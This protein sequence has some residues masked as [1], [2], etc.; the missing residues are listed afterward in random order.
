M[1]LH[2]LLPHVKPAALAPPTT[3]PTPD[4]LGATFR[5]HPQVRKAVR[6][7]RYT[8]VPAARY[9]C[10]LCHH[11]FRV[12]PL[13]VTAAHTSQRVRG[14]GVMFYLL[15]LSYGASALALEALGV[16]LA[17]S[18]VYEAV[19]AAVRGLP[20]LQQ[21]AVFAGLRTPALGADLTSVLCNGE[22]RTLGLTV[23]AV[24]GLT[25]RIDLLEGS[26]AATIQEWLAPIVE[27][28]GAE[29][30][31]T[32]DA[33]S[34]KQAADGLG[35]THQVCKAPVRRNTDALV[36][37][38]VAKVVGDPDGSLGAIGVPVEQAQADLR[39]L[40]EVVRERQPEQ[41]YE[42]DALHQ[43][44]KDAAPPAKG[45]KWSLAYRLRQLFLDRAQLWQRLTRY[46]S[47]EGPEGEQI[48]GTN[49]ASERG[50]GWWVKER[51]RT[52]RGYKQPQAA[53]G[54]SRLVAWA[55][56]ALGGPGADLAQVLG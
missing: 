5:L 12:Y 43:R 17:K 44:Y 19:Q 28:V 36:A 27:A 50:I 24:S 34:M 23:D 48:D 41:G 20:D 38:L 15:G 16:P 14:L 11:T 13:G 6:D 2:L 26:D 49:N 54:V 51:Y 31:V 33:D 10:L 45:E 47:G 3:C 25:L 29:L 53:V 40:G 52:M 56:N 18:T 30:L 39:R 42:V 35:L 32:D 46:R 37:E 7:T 21:R 22:W 55:G 8:Q 1:R 9:Q 4:C